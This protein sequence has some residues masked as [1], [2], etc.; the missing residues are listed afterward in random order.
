MSSETWGRVL[1][2][3]ICAWLCIVTVQL[4]STVG[5]LA[6]VDL[7][8]FWYIVLGVS[9]TVWLVRGLAELRGRRR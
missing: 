5:V 9:V 7:G 2:V 8:V 6:P 3:L 1:V 4:L